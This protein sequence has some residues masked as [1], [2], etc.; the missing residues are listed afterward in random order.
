MLFIGIV[1]GASATLVI[2]A[3]CKVAG[4]ADEAKERMVKK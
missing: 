2:L 3:L 4:E 1:I